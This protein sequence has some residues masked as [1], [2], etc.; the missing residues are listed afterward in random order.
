[1]QPLRHLPAATT[2][3]RAFGWFSIALGAAELLMPGPVSRGTGLHGR[4]SL[5]RAYGVREIVTGIGLLTSRRPGLWMWARVVGDALDAGTLARGRGMPAQVSLGIV[6]A[7]AAA[8]VA[9]AAAQSRRPRQQPAAHDYSDRSGLPQPPSQMRGAARGDFETPRDM[10]S[11][12]R[13]RPYTPD[14]AS[15]EPRP[16]AA[17]PRWTNE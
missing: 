11:R 10:Q 7:V 12:P 6:A 13:V 15:N 5:L 14:P 3:A 1:M 4:Q 2:L 8:D 17:G 16:A 9:C